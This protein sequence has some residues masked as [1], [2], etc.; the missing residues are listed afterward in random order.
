MID[1]I[2]KTIKAAQD[3]Q[4]ALT[5]QEER[6]MYRLGDVLSKH[7]IDSV[8]QLDGILKEIDNASHGLW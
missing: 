8:D 3:D 1:L 4:S 6:E 5:D 7:S 2:Q